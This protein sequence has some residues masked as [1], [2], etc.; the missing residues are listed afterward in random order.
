[1]KT[2][3]QKPWTAGEIARTFVICGLLG[4]ITIVALALTGIKYGLLL[5]AKVVK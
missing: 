2:F 1:M 5:A 3:Q 4:G